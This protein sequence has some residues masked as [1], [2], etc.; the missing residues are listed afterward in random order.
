[1]KRN[2]PIVEIWVP[3]STPETQ[4]EQIRSRYKS[5]G[6]LIVIYRSGSNCLVEQTKHLLAI[7][8]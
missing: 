5:S 4:V 6:C 3:T 7:N 2:N 1:M 8:C